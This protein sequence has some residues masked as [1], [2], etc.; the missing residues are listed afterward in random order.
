MTTPACSTWI[1]RGVTWRSR[2]ALIVTVLIVGCLGAMAELQAA[3]APV[4]SRLIK[5]PA[6]TV[7]GAP[8]GVG[9]H[10]Y[11]PE[12]YQ[13]DGRSPLLIS[14]ASS[15]DS[16]SAAL[17]Q[18]LNGG[19]PVC[20][21]AGNNWPAD[22]PL[23]VLS[24]Q[25]LS[26]QDPAVWW[27]EFITF[28][29]SYYAI[30]PRCITLTGHSWAAALCWGYVNRYGG[31]DAQ[32]QLAAFIPLGQVLDGMAPLGVNLGKTNLWCFNGSFDTEWA[33]NP[34]RLDPLDDIIALPSPPRLDVRKTVDAGVDHSAEPWVTYDTNR[35][36]HD[37]YAWMISKRKV[38]PGDTVPAAG[39]LQFSNPMVRCLEG[40]SGSSQQVFRVSRTGGSS[41][42]VTV[43]YATRDGIARASEGDYAA[44]SGT[45]SWA[46]GDL[47]E[48]TFAVTVNGDTGKEMDETIN[49]ALS[50]PTNGAILGTS[51]AEVT[52]L[53]DDGPNGIFQFRGG[54]RSVAEGNSGTSTHT[55]L[56]SRTGGSAGAVAVQYMIFNGTGSRTAYSG[57]GIYDDGLVDFTPA[58]TG[59]LNW[60]D[61]D[62]SDKAVTVQVL[63][64]TATEADEAVQLT[65]Y[66]PT[67]GAVLGSECSVALTIANDDGI[68]PPPILWQ[69]ASVT[70]A[71]GQCARFWAISRSNVRF[72]Y[73]WQSAP[74]GSST[75]SNIDVSGTSQNYFTPPATP[76]MNGTQYRCLVTNSAGTATS[77]IATLTVTGS[78][79]APAI[80]TQPSASTVT[81]PVSATFSVSASGSPA[82]TYQWQSAPPGSST[83]TAISGATSASYATG[84]TT[85]GMN[86]RQYRCVVS[87]S[88]GTITSS[89]AALTVQ[90]TV[91]MPQ[92]AMQP[93]STAVTSSTTATFTIAASSSPAPTY[94][95]ESA[96]PGSSTFTPISGATAASYSTA[97]T[98]SMDGTQYRCVVSNSAGSVTSAAVTLSIA[99]APAPLPAATPEIGGKSGGCGS[100]IGSGF[101]VLMLLLSCAHLLVRPKRTR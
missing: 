56:I 62:I 78:T 99:S 60:T 40:H 31:D 23:V 70:V 5:R 51:T 1:S 58:T 50:S 18:N 72:A 10:E 46:S 15:G 32:N 16:S 45:L 39:Q 76:S 21:I 8:A 34:A 29:T 22:R 96:A 54:N 93:T 7:P 26:V 24:P 95:W 75:F 55:F 64:D 61:G 13:P 65:L 44:A 68:V 4:S 27:R 43:S 85:V 28:A 9:W 84:A 25:P 12:S 57:S 20:L 66:N 73:Q 98:P 67:N 71:S 88:A 94:Q 100:G 52:V 79:A 97:T 77:A 80:T 59:T 19:G 87:N 17:D 86:G 3:T 30:D 49:V 101:S 42:A 83:F 11:L 36:G 53:N 6:G 35:A 38:M 2:L 63:G 41:G 91:S 37:I 33:A 47:G 82:P 48:K 14:L 92:I 74:P 81:A 69:P 90:S 89:S